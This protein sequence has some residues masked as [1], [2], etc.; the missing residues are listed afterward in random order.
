[1]AVTD[2]RGRAILVPLVTPTTKR[3]RGPL[4]PFYLNPPERWQPVRARLE[5]LVREQTHH[6]MVLEHLQARIADG[7]FQVWVWGEGDDVDAVFL[8]TLFRQPNGRPVCSLSWA[9]GADAIHPDAIYPTIEAWARTQGC[10]ALVIVGRKG[11]ERVM[12]PHGF[13]LADQ[14]IIKEL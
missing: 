4:T 14:T 8:T 3:V 2:E 6:G 9:A 1:V 7:H 11:W 13:E 12:R 10:Q 5:R